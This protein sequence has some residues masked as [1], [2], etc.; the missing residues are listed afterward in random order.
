MTVRGGHKDSCNWGERARERGEGAGMNQRVMYT[1]LRPIG[2][3]LVAPRQGTSSRATELG[4]R[5]VPLEAKW[6][7]HKVWYGANMIET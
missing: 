3:G 4:S 7:A 1:C 2:G 5:R 6:L